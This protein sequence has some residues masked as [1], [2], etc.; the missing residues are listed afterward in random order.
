M[1]T[2]GDCPGF[3]Q[4]KGFKAFTCRCPNY[5][6]AKE[7]FSDGLV[8][9]ISALVAARRLILPNVPLKLQEAQRLHPKGSNFSSIFDLYPSGTHVILHF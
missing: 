2:P 3:E 5:G 1:T 8:E 9:D 7:V 6:K 4:C